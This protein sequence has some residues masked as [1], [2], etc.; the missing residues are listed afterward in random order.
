MEEILGANEE[1]AQKNQSRLNKLGILTVNVMS[2]PGAGKTSL[3]LQTI[4]STVF[5]D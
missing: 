2:S 1:K 4:K 3:L 5:I